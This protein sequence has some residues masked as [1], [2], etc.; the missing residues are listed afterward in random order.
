MVFYFIAHRHAIAC[1]SHAARLVT[2][3]RAI[4]I[5][6]PI[7]I[8]ARA[9]DGSWRGRVFASLSRLAPR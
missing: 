6:A 3:P 8:G 7:P 4:L 5:M 2:V 1:L 9:I